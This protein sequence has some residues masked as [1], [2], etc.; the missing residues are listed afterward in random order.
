MTRTTGWRPC[1]RGQQGELHRAR[2]VVLE[3]FAPAAR[4]FPTAMGAAGVGCP[5][6]WQ[7]E[8]TGVSRRRVLATR[9]STRTAGSGCLTVTTPPLLAWQFRPERV[10]I[11][12]GQQPVDG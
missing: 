4:A 6:Q 12:A 7:M 10:N 3:S 8:E 9:S 5:G 2:L 1:V 11:H